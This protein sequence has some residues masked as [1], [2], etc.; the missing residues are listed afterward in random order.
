MT[1]IPLPIACYALGS[2]G[3]VPS[4]PSLL[5][6]MVA[7]EKVKAGKSILVVE[8]IPPVPVKIVDA[9]HHWEYSPL[10][11]CGSRNTPHGHNT[12][13]RGVDINPSSGSDGP[14]SRSPQEKKGDCGHCY[15]VSDILG[16]GSHPLHQSRQEGSWLISITL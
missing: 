9:I 5:K 15:M 12:G 11:V 8:R 7:G 2:L 4:L 16:P 1:E 14:V 3:G 10:G 13:A 6:E